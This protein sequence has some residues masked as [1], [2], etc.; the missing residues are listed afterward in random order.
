MNTKVVANLTASQKP[1]RIFNCEGDLE[2]VPEGK[3]EVSQPIA[4]QYQDYRSFLIRLNSR[5]VSK[6]GEI[7]VL[8]KTRILLPIYFG[9]VDRG[10]YMDFDKENKI[11]GLKISNYAPSESNGLSYASLGSDTLKTAVLNSFDQL[12]DDFASD[13]G[14]T[15]FVVLLSPT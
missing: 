2:W 14:K 4:H 3:H 5:G 6:V 1:V 10:F 8:G 7:E 15:R 13:S 12:R 9:D 11:S